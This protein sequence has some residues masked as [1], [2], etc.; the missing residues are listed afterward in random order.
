MDKLRV[1]HVGIA[2]HDISSLGKLLLAALGVEAVGQAVEDPAQE[3]VLQMYRQGQTWLELIA[4]L[5][6]HSHVRKAL[7]K[8]GEGPLHICFETPDLE[9]TLDRVRAQGLLVFRRPTPAALFGGKRVAFAMAPGG[10]V[11]EFVEAG[12]EEGLGKEA[13]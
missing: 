12:W 9:G 13:T 10:M 1:A 2:T 4:P 8:R 11:F 3:A 7:E 6:E 5:G